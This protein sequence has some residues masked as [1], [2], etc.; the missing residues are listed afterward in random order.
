MIME[1]NQI[2]NVLLSFYEGFFE[3]FAWNGKDLNIKVE[4]SYL[5]E[6][7]NPDYKYF[8]GTIKNVKYFYFKPWD[9]DEGVMSDVKDLQTLKLDILGIEIDDQRLKI[10]SNCCHSYTGGNIFLEASQIKI[11]DEMF[12]EVNPA[13]LQELSEKYW[14]AVGKY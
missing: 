5:A 1:P 6:L 10:Y 11:Y 2:R 12:E 3:E 13:F 14:E 9:D 8:Y 4:C 7:I